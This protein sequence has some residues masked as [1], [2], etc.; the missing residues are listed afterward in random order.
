MNFVAFSPQFPPNF[1]PFYSN[2]RRMG[3]NVL[4]L[5]RQ[6]MLGLGAGDGR[7][8]FSRVEPVL[9]VLRRADAA[10]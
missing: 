8:G 9:L 10:T 2:L 4:G 6:P 7:N 3:V 1:I 5:K